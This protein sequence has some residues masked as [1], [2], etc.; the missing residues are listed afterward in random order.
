M[1]GVRVLLI[2]LPILENVLGCRCRTK[3]EAAAVGVTKAAAGAGDRFVA[4]LRA[5]G[6]KARAVPPA[7]KKSDERTE[8]EKFMITRSISPRKKKHQV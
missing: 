6:V 1:V 8:R 3:D 4:V 2:L 5:I 7:M